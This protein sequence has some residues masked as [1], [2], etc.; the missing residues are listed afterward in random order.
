MSTLTLRL[1]PGVKPTD[2][3]PLFRAIEQLAWRF[4]CQVTRSDTLTYSLI[5]NHTTVR[6]FSPRAMT[7][8]GP[9]AA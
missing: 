7:S 1:P 6:Q 8:D 9:E 2:I 3:E 4:D 5:P